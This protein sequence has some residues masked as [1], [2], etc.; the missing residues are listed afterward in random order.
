MNFMKWSL[1]LL[2]CQRKSLHVRKETV[3]RMREIYAQTVLNFR[4]TYVGLPKFEFCVTR[5]RGSRLFLF[6]VSI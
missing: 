1:W 5:I 6:G 2:N 4:I 3:L